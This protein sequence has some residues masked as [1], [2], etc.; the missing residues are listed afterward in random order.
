MSTIDMQKFFILFEARSGSSHLVS[1][2][3]S[4]P[5]VTCYA[6][7]YTGQ[8]ER[9]ANRLTAAFLAGEPL[10]T[11]NKWALDSHGSV[12]VEKKPECMGFKTKIYD[13]P[14]AKHK[15]RRLEA[16]GV[17]MILLTRT[18][19]L[20]QAISR[21]AS[22]EL[23]SRNGVYNASSQESTVGRLTVDPAEIIDI[24]SQYE[25]SQNLIQQRF[26]AWSGPK[27]SLTYEDMLA[28]QTSVIDQIR[29]LFGLEPFEHRS[30]VAKNVDDS[31]ET[32]I[33]NYSELSAALNGHS[34]SRFL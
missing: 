11:I 21:A 3:N 18:N 23:Y 6:E 4:S 33:E 26:E 25:E 32:A 7:V 28:D 2:L 1:L 13:V 5:Q 17:A 30:G 8:S 15:L 27:L 22:L 20:K 19:L 14:H 29:D 31:L 24:A 10:H 9:V 12:D 34:Y 16:A